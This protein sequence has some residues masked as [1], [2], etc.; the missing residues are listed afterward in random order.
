M[1]ETHRAAATD[2]GNATNGQGLQAIRR[3][4]REAAAL[5]QCWPIRVAAVGEML[6]EDRQL[7]AFNIQAI[8]GDRVVEVVDVELQCR[9]AAVTI[10]IFEGVGERL[11]ACA[12]TVQIDEVW[13]RGVQCVGVGTVRREYQF[14]VHTL[15][16][17]RR[18]RPAR[19][20]VSTLD[21]VRQDVARQRQMILGSG[22]RVSVGNCRRYIIDNGD[23]DVEAGTATIGIGGRYRERFAHV[24]DAF[25]TGMTFPALQGKAEGHLTGQRVVGDRQLV[26]EAGGGRLWRSDG[27]TIADQIDAADGKGLQAIGG[28]DFE[29]TAT[30]Q[31]RR[32]RAAAI[33][34]VFLVE[35]QRSAIDAQSADDDWIIDVGNIE[36]QVGSAG[37][38]VGILEGVGEGLDT[39]ATT[40]QLDEIRISTVQRIGVGAISGQHQRAV[41]ASEGACSDWPG[42][43]AIRTLHI[44]TQD[45]T[46]QRQL[47]L[48]GGECIAVIHRS[49]RVVSNIDIQRTTGDITVGIADRNA[50]ALTQP[51]GTATV[52]VR[53]STGQGVAVADHTGRRIVAGD[54]QNVAKAGGNRLA[55]SG[56]R[57]RGD[58]VDTTDVEVEYPIRRYHGKTAG[59]G[60]C[61]GVTGRALGQISLVERQFAALHLQAFEGDRV[62]DHWR[63]WRCVIVVVE[64]AGIRRA[65]FCKSVETSRREAN[66][67]SNPPSHFIEQNEG[68]SSTECACGPATA[69]ASRSRISLLARVGT[70]SDSLLEL[71]Y[72]SQL[73]LARRQ[74]LG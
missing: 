74:R 11:D 2:H 65:Q 31:C 6:L 45:I 55:D 23:I 9:R 67:W 1:R 16:G 24:V 35:R 14:A 56:H 57:T 62:I 44:I 30:G 12:T 64:Q 37:I 20:T 34:Q 36:Y 42:G 7:T 47:I 59:L 46:G 13:I 63:Q 39:A 40:V 66:L 32:I 41:G 70:S 3:R 73:R 60:Q 69:G 72:I 33:S 27:H 48:T 21:V 8:E 28:A 22:D 58:D 38:A 50:D 68:V 43:N 29:S 18:N 19:N 25:T 10:R 15:K 26:T 54:G 17:L 4:H 61:R 5:G 71:L 52:R 49:R 53:F 51:V